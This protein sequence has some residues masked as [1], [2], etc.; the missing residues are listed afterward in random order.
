M[1]RD[2]KVETF[3]H[4]PVL[5][6]E[7][8][9]ALNIKPDGIYVDCTAGGGGHSGGIADRLNEKGLLISL[10]KDDEAIE[11]CEAKAKAKAE[12]GKTWKIVKSDFSEITTVL[13]DMNIDKVDGILADLGVSSHQIDTAQRGFSYAV[14]GPLDMRMDETQKVSAYEVVNT[15]DA[16]R[17]E[18]IFRLYG[19]ERY[20]GR[21]ASGIVRDRQEKPFTS[22]VE[23]AKAIAS[24]MPGKA[25]YEDQHPARRCF[26]AIRIEVNHELDSVRT[27][28]Q[29]GPK[30]LSEGG[31]MAVISFHSLEDRIVKEEFRTLQDPCTCPKNLPCV[32]GKKSLGRV[33]TRKPITAC[34]EELKMNNRSHSAK[35]RIFE[36]TDGRT[37]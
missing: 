10:D 6:N 16:R 17:L 27:L 9:E 7:C 20:A 29:E 37:N 23:L 15:Y 32:C 19:E 28:L 11:V 12:E 3:T 5:F 36:R 2:S 13:D 18:E 26:Q 34:D 25:R 21:I 8:M 33:I 22:T 14:D 35:L 24:Y 30:R 4:I 1:D 31:R